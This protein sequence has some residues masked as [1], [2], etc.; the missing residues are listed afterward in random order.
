MSLKSYL[1]A[2]LD[3]W[4]PLE[5]E[6]LRANRP[7]QK[8]QA[9]PATLPAPAITYDTWRAGKLGYGPKVAAPRGYGQNWSNRLYC[10]RAIERAKRYRDNDGTK[11]QYRTGSKPHRRHMTV[12]SAHRQAWDYGLEIAEAVYNRSINNEAQHMPGYWQGAKEII[13]E[14]FSYT[15]YM[16][17]I[18]GN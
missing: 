11:R 8:R 12:K 16:L 15:S 5:P 10:E 2:K 13:D 1:I 9:R 17:A 14:A 18:A 7:K 6:P 3:K 4:F